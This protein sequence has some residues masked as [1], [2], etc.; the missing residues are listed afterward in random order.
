MPFEPTPEI[1]NGAEQP[2][3]VR[4]QRESQEM[5]SKLRELK[6]D[7][8]SAP[9]MAVFGENGSRTAI[10]LGKVEK[11]GISQEHLMISPKGTFTVKGP[12]DLNQDPETLLSSLKD[13]ARK[14]PATNVQI[15][16]EYRH[17]IIDSS[18]DK[19]PVGRFEIN[20]LAS[21]PED[22]PELLK[23]AIESSRKIAQKSMSDE[24]LRGQN[25]NEML[26]NMIHMANQPS[27]Q[28][29]TYPESVA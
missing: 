9:A 19:G 10:F 14:R 3:G 27:S 5:I 8:P 26:T 13:V 7:D 28:T 25:G 2:L 24:L 6:L 20:R 15:D 22:F 21:A 16:E 18:E 12:S 4:V 11:N 29:S 23:S 17:L 1:I